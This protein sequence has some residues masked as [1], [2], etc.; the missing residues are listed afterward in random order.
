MDIRVV[1]VIGCIVTIFSGCGSDTIEKV[2][3]KVQKESYNKVSNEISESTNL[4]IEVALNEHNR[5]RSEVYSDA[6]MVWDDTVAQTAQEYAQYLAESGK[7]EHD[8]GSGY[9]ENLAVTYS[10]SPY[11]D[12]VRMWEEEKQYYH[13]DTNSCDSG[14][15]CGHYTQVVWKSS[16][17][18]GCGAARYEK[19]KYTGAWVVVCR[20]DPP[21]NYIG[22]RPY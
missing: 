21:G 8:M 14:K 15:T 13:Y 11:K 17:H 3:D 6:P 20:Y 22:E 16:T 4:S 19:G 10:T 1:T 2:K 7:L 18:L 12:A 9:G 5:V